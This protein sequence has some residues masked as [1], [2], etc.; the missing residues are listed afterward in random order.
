MRHL[1]VFLCLCALQFDPACAQLVTD[2][3]VIEVKPTPED[4]GITTP[5]DFHNKGTRPVR[6]VSIESACSCLKATLDKPLYQPGE[7]GTGKATFKLSG[8]TGMQEK[9]LHVHTDDSTRPEWL[10]RFAI[11]IPELIR[12]EPKTQQW[13][14]GEAALAK[15]T[16][17][18]L[19]GA[20]PM[21]IISI[22]S[23]S[24]QVS[25][26]WREITPGREYEITIKPTST[27]E[28][29]FGALKIETN[30]KIPKYVRQLA[31]FAVCR[32]PHK[33]PSN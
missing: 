9:T 7:K 2:Q 24:D 32:P 14:Q 5:F 17:I 13:E 15:T 31:Y 18:T 25:F 29:L 1:R 22:T 33:H 30:S 26:T 4:V 21:K 10:I 8:L 27:A 28:I 23:V 6:V 16:H 19:L 12:I 20:T 3:P 11:E